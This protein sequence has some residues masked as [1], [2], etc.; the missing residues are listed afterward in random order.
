MATG[1]SSGRPR[2]PRGKTNITADI[3]EEVLDKIP[4]PPEELTEDGKIVWYK[5][6]ASAYNWL[7]KADEMVILELCQLYEDKELYRRAIILGNVPRVYKMPN[8]ILTPHPY[9]NLL[10]DTRAQMNTLL[11]ALGFTPTD[12]AKIGAM[13]QLADDPILSMVK[14]KQEREA[15]RWEKTH[16]SE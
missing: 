5:I 15:A 10:K 12:R 14:R 4:P 3:T 1:R 8:G 9:V 16:G 7:S 6:W 11:A 13:E 2:K